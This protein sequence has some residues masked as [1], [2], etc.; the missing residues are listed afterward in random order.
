[1]PTKE[2]DRNQRFRYHP[3]FLS[4][5]AAI[6]DVLR[7]L[8]HDLQLGDGSLP[9]TALPSPR[10]LV[11]PRMPSSSVSSSSRRRNTSEHFPPCKITEH[12]FLLSSYHPGLTPHCPGSSPRLT[13]YISTLSL[14]SNNTR[15]PPGTMRPKTTVP[16]IPAS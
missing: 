5:H 11:H 4:C 16:T 14:S 13:D 9:S 10:S 8:I 7:Q 2:I 15:Q 1:M 3:P 12:V 6:R